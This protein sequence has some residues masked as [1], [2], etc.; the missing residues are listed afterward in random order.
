[1]KTIS[2]KYLAVKRID[3]E[4]KKNDID[5]FMEEVEKKEEDFE[6][7]REKN[8]SIF[9]SMGG[10]NKDFFKYSGFKWWI[11][12]KEIDREEYIERLKEEK[13][14]MKNK[15]KEIDNIIEKFII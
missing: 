4:E 11:E 13:E 12:K 6:T 7:I 15:L 10:I 2:E 9:R 5:L 3:L 14:K 8:R 1:M